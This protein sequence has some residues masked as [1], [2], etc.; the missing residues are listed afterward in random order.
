[1]G[2]VLCKVA[3]TLFLPSPLRIARILWHMIPFVRQGID[4]LRHR[5]MKVELL[6]AMSYFHL[7]L[8]KGFWNCRYG[9]VFVG[10]GR[11]AG[12]MDKEKIRSRPCPVHVIER[13]P[14]MGAYWTRRG[15]GNRSHKSSLGDAVI[16]RAGGIIPMD[17]L[18]L[19]G[20]VTVNQA[21]LTGESIP[22][23]KHPGGNSLCR[24]RC[25]RRRMRF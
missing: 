1:M 23:S 7:C 14:C 24:N 11:T 15:A 8:Q 17:G 21:S 10:S 4:C 9:D 22:V 18:V 19:D 16:V 3:S 6:D 2:K 12:K 25:G 20:E 5:H 13:R